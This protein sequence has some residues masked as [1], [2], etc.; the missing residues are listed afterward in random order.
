MKATPSGR[1]A[2]TRR[3]AFQPLLGSGSFCW[4]LLGGALFC[5]ILDQVAFNMEE[6]ISL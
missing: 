1:S 3:Y 5:S 6:Q 4:L 2:G